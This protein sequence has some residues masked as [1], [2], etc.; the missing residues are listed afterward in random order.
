MGEPR[1]D[2][3]ERLSI[4]VCCIP[5]DVLGVCSMQWYACGWTSME[6]LVISDDKR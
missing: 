6:G 1:L 3:Y 2:I 5:G 4:E